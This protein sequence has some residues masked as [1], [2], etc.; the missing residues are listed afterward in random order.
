MKLLPSQ[1]RFRRLRNGHFQKCADVFQK[2]SSCQVNTQPVHW[3][4]RKYEKL[5]LLSA[6]PPLLPPSP[7]PTRRGTAFF[8]LAFVFPS[9]TILATF[10]AFLVH[11]SLVYDR[12]VQVSSSTA[13]FVK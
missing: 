4:D 12:A 1:T 11:A 8:T 5:G 2:S 13:I 6:P 9:A 3:A 10:T 7:S